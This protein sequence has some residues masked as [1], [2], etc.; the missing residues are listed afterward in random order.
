M[1]QARDQIHKKLLTDWDTDGDGTI[2]DQEREQAKTKLRDM[3]TECRETRFLEADTSGDK[4]LSYDEFILLPG[5]A[6]KVIDSPELVVAIFDRLNGDDDLISLEEFLA[7]VQQCDQ[8]RDG[9][10]TGS[11]GKN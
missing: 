11:S 5:M 3:I 10:G 1:D 9:T 8:A 4:L 7:A 6:K 2:C